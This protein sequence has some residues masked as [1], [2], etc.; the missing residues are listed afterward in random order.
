M[1]ARADI[2]RYAATVVSLV[3]VA[4][5]S[6]F[7]QGQAD[8]DAINRLID[9]YGELEDA[10]D[11]MSQAGLMAEDRVWIAQGAG[12][13]T[14]QVQNIRIQQAQNDNIRKTYPGIAFHTEDRD[15]LIKFY[16]NSTVAVASFYRYRTAVLPPD[17]P[18]EML[19]A[20]GSIPA[21]VAT[22][23]LEKRS[24]EWK[25]VHTHFSALGPPVGN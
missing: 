11:M 14:N 8:V 10:G 20:F 18:P 16:G 13:R 7:A 4:A 22:L 21:S 12:R 2:T 9:R 23:V 5:G 6:A 15:R 17:T 24:G 25:I 1:R 3:I 19:A